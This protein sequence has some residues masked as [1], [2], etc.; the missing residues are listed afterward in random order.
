MQ[1]LNYYVSIILDIILTHLQIKIP[2]LYIYLQR[3]NMI[4]H[5]TD[6]GLS[7]TDDTDADQTRGAT[8]DTDSCR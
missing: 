6:L 3:E 8:S 1:R 5:T 2:Y 7:I 4:C